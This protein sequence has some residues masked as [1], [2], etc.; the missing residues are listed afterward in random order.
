M[1]N[2]TEK[3]LKYSNKN[4][5]NSNIIIISTKVLTADHGFPIKKHIFIVSKKYDECA[6]KLN[7]KIQNAKSI[8]LQTLKC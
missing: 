3:F 1:I 4:L 2:I 6:I 5:K 7:S 8:F